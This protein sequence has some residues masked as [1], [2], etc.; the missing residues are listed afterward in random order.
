[1]SELLG[2]WA[3]ATA[4][5]SGDVPQLVWSNDEQKWFGPPSSALYFDDIMRA[6]VYFGEHAQRIARRLGAHAKVVPLSEVMRAALEA[7]PK[8]DARTVA[9]YLHERLGAHA[10]ATESFE[11]PPE[12][13]ADWGRPMRYLCDDRDTGENLEFQ[14]QRGGNGDWYLSVAEKGRRVTT[15]VRICTSGG[16]SFEVPEFTTAIVKAYDALYFAH[17]NNSHRGGV[18]AP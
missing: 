6:G 5:A 3:V 14:I 12:R 18:T 15:G 16:A 2:G 1:M 13:G 9:G 7:L 10:L 17:R 8:H 11:M 4:V